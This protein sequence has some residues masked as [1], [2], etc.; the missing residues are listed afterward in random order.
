MSKSEAD[1]AAEGIRTAIRA[2]T[3]VA[4]AREEPKEAVQAV[5]E[6]LTF[7]Q[8]ADYWKTLKGYQLVRPEDND[9]RIK[10]ISNF[11]LPSGERFG[12]KDIRKI[13]SRD[14]ENFRAARKAAGLSTVTTNHDLKLLRKMWNWGIRVKL[15][16]EAADPPQDVPVYGLS[17]TPFRVGGVAFISIE[18]E[19]P[20]N[21]RFSNIGDEERLL[22]LADPRM[23]AFITTMLDTCTRP[24][25]L[26]TLQW[27]AVDLERRV[28]KLKAAGRGQRAKTKTQVG[29][30]VPLS[31]RAVALMELRQ[32]LP[33]GERMPE[34]AYVWQ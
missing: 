14:I 2:G 9:S 28:V 4:V 3:F 21:E 24:G 26:R 10:T 18:K 19:T 7:A 34:T 8:F 17:G 25:E 22:A 11:V 16:A 30:T 15:E 23:R 5:A 6:G 13:T 20:R 29:R 33:D 31:A 32:Y 27:A 1:R 12:D